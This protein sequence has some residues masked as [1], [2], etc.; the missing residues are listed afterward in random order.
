MKK[1]DL[2]IVGGGI[3]GTFCAYH[4]LRL[5]KSVLLLEKDSIPYEGSFRNFGQG[6]PSG[7][8]LDKWFEYGR[9]S[10]KIYSELQEET[11]ISVVKNGSWYLASDDFEATMLEEIQHIFEESAKEFP[12][13]TH[14]Y[15]HA[16]VSVMP[17]YASLGFQ[18][19]GDT[20]VEAD[21]VHQ[22]MALNYKA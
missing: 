14:Y 18:P 2:I 10:L 12:D 22:A 17:L 7:Q 21:I 13:C 5:K 20:F 4:A 19:Y 11:D 15:L 16:Q 9:K 6:V 8:S 3:I 1:Y